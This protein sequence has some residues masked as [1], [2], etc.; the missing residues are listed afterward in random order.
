MK[1][2][3]V[4]D[5]IEHRA[6][7]IDPSASLLEAA[8]RMVE[9]ATDAFIVSPL[10]KDA[11]FGIITQRDIVDLFADEVDIGKVTVGEMASKPLLIVSPGMPI[12]YA[13]K[14]FRKGGVDHLAVFNG[15]E[16]LGIISC[17]DVLG[18]LPNLMEQIYSEF[19]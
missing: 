16:I 7:T 18:S 17:N 6:Q 13:A 11:P 19:D 3:K 10:E 12:L 1:R 14:M 2:L 15:Q 8:R 5:V 9:D 4:R